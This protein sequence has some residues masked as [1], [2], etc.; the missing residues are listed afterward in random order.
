M[1]MINSGLTEVPVGLFGLAISTTS[2]WLS[3]M[4]ATASSRSMLKSSRRGKVR[5]ALWVSRA[6][7]GYIE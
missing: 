7:S 3:R 4:A 1:A 5:Q 6:Y 2:G